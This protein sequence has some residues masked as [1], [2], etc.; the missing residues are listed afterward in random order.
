[1]R[2]GL[3]GIVMSLGSLSSPY[4]LG[5]SDYCGSPLRDSIPIGISYTQPKISSVNSEI[6]FSDL[7]R[8]NVTALSQ[9]EREE[10]T[11]K[12]RMRESSGRANATSFV[13]RKRRV[14]GE[15]FA[16]TIHSVGENQINISERG[17][18][19]DYNAFHKRRFSAEDMLNPS[20]NRVVRDWYLFRRIP[21]ILT[22]YGLETSVANILASYNAGHVKLIK[23]GGNALDE[24]NFKKLPRITQKYIRELTEEDA[25]DLALKNN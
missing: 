25:E 22:F 13:V 18:L 17:A 10:L 7:A 19:E 2:N 6:Y 20:K 3:I 12:L 15:I 24:D 8:K 14:N 4:S 21:Q 5:G 1:M 23:A 11:S 16:D 9:S